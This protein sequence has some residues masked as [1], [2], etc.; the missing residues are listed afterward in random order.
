MDDRPRLTVFYDGACRVCD[1]EICHYQ[2]IENTASIV[3]V[4]ISAPDF[5][6]TRHGLSYEE[7]MQKMHVIDAEG[8]VHV[9]VDAFR[10]LWQQLPGL[11][12]H[13][14]AALVSL[15]GIR[16]LAGVGYSL[17]ARHRHHF[18]KP[19]RS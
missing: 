14:L 15:P 9:G 10:R 5:D 8:T 17:F 13:L 7:L 18:A 6:A 4:D 11:H 16:Q 1:R 19:D 2:K 12:Y 3:Y